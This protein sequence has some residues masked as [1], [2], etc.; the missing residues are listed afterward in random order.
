MFKKILLLSLVLT[1]SCSVVFAQEVAAEEL[2]ITEPGLFYWLRNIGWDIQAL[3]TTDPIKKSELKLKKASNQ[4]LRARQLV[5]K[6]PDDIR[7]QERLENLNKSY[8]DLVDGIDARIE[9]FRAE[10]QD[11]AQLKDFMDKYIAQRLRHQEILEKLG[12]QVPEAVQERIQEHREE[13]LEKFGDVMSKLQTNEELKERLQ[14]AIGNVKEDITRRLNRFEIIEQIEEKAAPAVRNEIQNRVNE[15]KQEQPQIIQQLRNKAEE[16]KIMVQE[17][18]Q[19]FQEGVQEKTQEYREN[20]EER[21][22]IREEHQEAIEQETQS[23]FQGIKE[24]L[25]IHS[26]SVDSSE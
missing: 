13:Q 25:Q 20:W 4:L 5:E 19:D 11:D 6:D 23:F 8:E 16:L 18:A 24:R 12:E 3:L 21:E 15:I 2:D 22:E 26:P 10:N 1:L 7:L 14:E 9:A 17:R